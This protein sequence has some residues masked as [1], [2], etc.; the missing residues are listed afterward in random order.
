MR[1]CGL[2]SGERKTPHGTSLDRHL[3]VEL[4]Q[5]AGG[6]LSQGPEAGPLKPGR[7]LGFQAERL[8]AFLSGLP[9]GQRVALGFRDPL[10]T[11]SRPARSWKPMAPP[12]APPSRRRRAI[13]ADDPGPSP[14]LKGSFH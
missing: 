4:S 6:L 2:F 13:E 14:G 10:G 1:R 5:L 11:A 7:W 8:N 9:A 12:S 3:G